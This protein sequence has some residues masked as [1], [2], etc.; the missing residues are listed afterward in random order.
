MVDS[1]KVHK[2]AMP[3]KT[4]FRENSETRMSHH[5]DIRRLCSRHR[6]LVTVSIIDKITISSSDAIRARP[7]VQLLAINSLR[8]FVIKK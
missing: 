8:Y 3:R 5:V 4:C 1:T 6:H 2:G 7:S